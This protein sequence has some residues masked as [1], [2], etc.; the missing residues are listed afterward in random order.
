MRLLVV[1]T[2]VVSFVFKNHPIG[3][4]YEADLAG[5]TLLI[6]FMTLVR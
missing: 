1:D 2:D 6:S 3:A 5:C 4:Q